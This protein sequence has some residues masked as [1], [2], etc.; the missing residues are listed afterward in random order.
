MFK[1]E[2]KIWPLCVC[3]SS[4]Y[5][6]LFSSQMFIFCVFKCLSTWDWI[7]WLNRFF[8]SFLFFL[9]LFCYTSSPIKIGDS[10]LIRLILK[11]NKNCEHIFYLFWSLYFLII[12]LF[13]RSLGWGKHCCCCCFTGCNSF[14]GSWWSTSGVCI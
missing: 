12:L 3:V 6:A 7:W 2:I 4:V 1:N 9:S 5:F 10:F 14:L 8:S 11:N 13:E